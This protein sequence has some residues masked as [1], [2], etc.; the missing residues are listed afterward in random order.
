MSHWMYQTY[1]VTV[2]SQPSPKNPLDINE[3]CLRISA[4]WG[5]FPHQVRFLG[6][7]CLHSGKKKENI[8]ARLYLSHH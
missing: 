7:L 8:L 2:H 5:R 1:Y 6:L 3:R 4:C